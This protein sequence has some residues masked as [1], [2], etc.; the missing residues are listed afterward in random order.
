MP[1]LLMLKELKDA[2]R[3]APIITSPA[4]DKYLVLWCGELVEYRTKCAVKMT[5]PPLQCWL[6]RQTL[7]AGEK[8][9]MYAET[10]IGHASFPT[11][12]QKSQAKACATSDQLFA[13]TP[14]V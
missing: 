1:G 8:P 2:R 10:F 7:A 14:T 13:L 4:A 6:I 12:E 11:L 5:V 3:R 9:T